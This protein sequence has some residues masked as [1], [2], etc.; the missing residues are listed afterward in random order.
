MVLMG[1]TNSWYDKQLQRRADSP[2]VEH[3]ARVREF[4]A[5]ADQAIA[6]ANRRVASIH[7]T[8]ANVSVLAELVAPVRGTL[9]AIRVVD[10]N[11]EPPAPVPWTARCAHQST[12]V[13]E[14][15][16]EAIVR[17]RLPAPKIMSL[18]EAYSIDLSTE[19]GWD[20]MDRLSE[21]YV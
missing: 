8:I 15:T 12:G 5:R 14:L 19:D 18:A 21:F 9:P 7:E 6:Y 3:M 11:P 20:T 17:L 1:T 2:V 16:P 4:I 13:V 10:L